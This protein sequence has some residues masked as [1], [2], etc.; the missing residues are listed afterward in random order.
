[1]WGIDMNKI[2]ENPLIAFAVGF[3]VFLG[4]FLLLDVTLMQ[5]QGLTLIFNG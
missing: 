5:A 2:L 1:M 4:V 3:A